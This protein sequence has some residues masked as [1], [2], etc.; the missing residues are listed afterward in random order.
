MYSRI[1]QEIEAIADGLKNTLNYTIDEVASALY[2]FGHDVNEIGT[3]IGNVFEAGSQEVLSALSSAGVT[4]EHAVDAV[5]DE[6]GAEL[7]KDFNL[8]GNSIA[9]FALDAEKTVEHFLTGDVKDFVEN[10]L[11][12]AGNFFEGV[13]SDIKDFFTGGDCVTM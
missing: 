10:T 1:E 6:A 7:S 8:V 12:D 13:G 11:S 9:G 5:F 4:I 3:I 2:D